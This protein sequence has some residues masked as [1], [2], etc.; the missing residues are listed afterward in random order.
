[1]TYLH[2]HYEPY[3][4]TELLKMQQMAK[5]YQI[6][7][8]ILYKTSIIG[9]LVERVALEKVLRVDVDVEN[10]MALASAHVDAEGFV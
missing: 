5:A 9:L 2:H 8:N 1:M 7:G 3:N 10:T 4:T 6:I